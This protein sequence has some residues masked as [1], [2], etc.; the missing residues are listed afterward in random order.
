MKLYGVSQ[1]PFVR[2]ARVVLEEKGSMR[3]RGWP[4]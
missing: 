1:S 3:T 2:K 4:R